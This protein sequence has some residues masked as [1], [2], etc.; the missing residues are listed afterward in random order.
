[1]RAIYEQITLA[2]P[3][4]VGVRLA[5]AAYERISGKAAEQIDR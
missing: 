4:I 5:A 2:G 1:M 3:E